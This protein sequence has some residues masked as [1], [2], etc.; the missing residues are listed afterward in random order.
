MI[1]TF[2]KVAENPNVRFFGN[3]EV[4]K[5]VSVAEL[6]ERYSALVFAYGADQDRTLGIPGID[7]TPT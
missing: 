7:E 4:N 5:D 1:T 6:K 2:E 3:V